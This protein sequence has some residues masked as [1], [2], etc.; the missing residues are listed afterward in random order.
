L[1]QRRSQRFTVTKR[2]RQLLADD[3]AGAFYR[4]LFIAYFRKFD[5]TY[6]FNLRPVPEFQIT[7][8]AILWRLDA[9]AGDWTSL[10]GLAPKILLP[11]VYERLHAA[12]TCPE[13]DT[14]EWILGG[15]VLSHLVDLGLIEVRN[16]DGMWSFRPE[17]EIRQ[18]RLWRKFFWFN[19]QF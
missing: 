8:A 11:K 19:F 12:M 17:D 9:V 1:I 10:Q 16:G 5:L 2:G 13:H 18:T 6:D 15:H 7:M 3:Q 14:E 4:T